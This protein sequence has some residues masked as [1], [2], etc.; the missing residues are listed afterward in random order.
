[1]L[2]IKVA[3][4]FSN[5]V[6]QQHLP[7]SNYESKIIEVAETCFIRA[8]K[9]V[10]AAKPVLA[11]LSSKY[12]LVLVSNF[13]GNINT[14]LKDFGISHFFNAVVE[15]AVVG[16]RKPDPAI[17]TLGVAQLG[18]PAADTVVIGDS[19]SK[20]MAPGKAAGCQTIWLNKAGWGD[21]P[22]DT[23]GADKMI[24][25]FAALTTIL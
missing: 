15:S 7:E 13:Y 10:E 21:D 3:Q 25:D 18:M 12:P 6:E 5:L 4:Q 17:F 8:Q 11:Y 14:I 19:F 24:E 23:S 2:R 20:D 1:M 16:V 22:E 9:S